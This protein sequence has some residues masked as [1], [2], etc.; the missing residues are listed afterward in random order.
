[1]SEL[2]SDSLTVADWNPLNHF[3]LCH[4]VL[5]SAPTRVL[6]SCSWRTKLSLTATTSAI[7]SRKGW[8]AKH[9]AQPTAKATSSP[10][11]TYPEQW[12]K[13]KLLAS[14][15]AQGLRSGVQKW[16]AQGTGSNG[17]Q[18]A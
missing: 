14:P 4:Y 3:I 7:L 6:V 17:G 5:P 2:C 18:P 11:A 9:A 16:V 15:D 1:M 10:A 12:R 13:R 8:L